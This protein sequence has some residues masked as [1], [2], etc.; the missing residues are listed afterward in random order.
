MAAD[1]RHAA[2]QSSYEVHEGLEGDLGLNLGL[3]YETVDFGA[4]VDFAFDFLERRDP[5]REGAVAALR[6]VRVQASERETVWTYSHS[7]SQGPSRDLVG[8][9]GFDVTRP[10]QSP[11]RTP[12]R[13]Q[14]ARR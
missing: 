8:V 12:A 5:R 1:P 6:I 10:W 13:P 3:R 14:T 11:Y 9:W 7:Q 4:A 2:G